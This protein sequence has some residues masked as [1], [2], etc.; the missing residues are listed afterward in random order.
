MDAAIICTTPDE[1]GTITLPEGY[2]PP[3]SIIFGDM[4]A[5]GYLDTFCQI[6]EIEICD[7][8]LDNVN[9]L[10]VTAMTQ[11]VKMNALIFTALEED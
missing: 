9:D 1:V 11:I 7:V 10:I 2:G 8:G 4:D 3:N 5:D 6:T